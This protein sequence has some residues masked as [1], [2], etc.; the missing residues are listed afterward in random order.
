MKFYHYTSKPFETIDMTKC[1]GFWFTDIAP[2][3]EDMLMEIGAQGLEYCAV[4]EFDPDCG[5]FIL[6]GASF[7]IEDELAGDELYIE[8]RYEA[9]SDYAV[10]DPNLV[11]I[12]E[13]IKL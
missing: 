8:N 2:N 13:W 7:D 6:N 5:D 9:F 1:D 11:K 10:I 3:Q 12:V 4:I